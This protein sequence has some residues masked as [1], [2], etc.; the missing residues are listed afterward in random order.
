MLNH[1]SRASLGHHGVRLQGEAVLQDEHTLYLIVEAADEVRLRAFLE[2]FQRAGSVD[3]YPAESCARAVTRGGC[4][5]PAV[6]NG[7][8]PALDPEEACQQAID[9]GLVVHRARPLNCETSLPALV[10]GV[11]MPNAR[12]YVRNHFQIPTIEA[13]TFTL[14][15]KGLVEWPLTLSLANLRK[16]RSQTLIGT[17]ECAGNGRTLFDPPP[18]GEKWEFGAVS[19]AEW[20]GIPLSEVLDL[21]DPKPGATDVVFHGADSGTVPGRADPIRFGRSLAI[22]HAKRGDALLAFAMNGEPLPVLHGYPLRLIV[23]R[24][25]AVASVKWLTDIEVTDRPFLGF[26]QAER[27]WYEWPRDGAIVREPVTLQRVRAV[28]TEPA[29]QATVPRGSLAVRGVAWSG[30]GPID[31]VDVS[32]NDGP[33]ERTELIAEPSR[34]S[35]QPW[36]L[37]THVYHAGALTL[38]ARATDADGNT[39]PTQPEWNRL[40]Y[41]NNAIQVVPIQAT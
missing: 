23:P 9:A 17:L 41:G 10:G 18:D 22:E 36:Q 16:M 26:Y 27:Y 35:W 38:R 34:H 20:T 39:Q 33:W 25:Y 3:V 29:A 32:V 15:V 21:A 30:A 14:T 19:T 6:P 24:W 28:I 5:A 4:H 11:V 12:F 13:D 8:I 40:G 37:M 1:L 31:R 2:P 7:P